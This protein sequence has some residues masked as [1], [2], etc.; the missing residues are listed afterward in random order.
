[1]TDPHSEEFTTHPRFDVAPLLLTAAMAL[2]FDGLAL[3]PLLGVTLPTRDG[4]GLEP[5]VALQPQL[6]V[7]ARTG[8]FLFG[9]SA[10]LQVPVV[11]LWGP[12][13]RETRLPR[14][15]LPDATRCRI[16]AARELWRVAVVLQGE[17]WAW[18]G[19]S[20]GLSAEGGFRDDDLAELINASG[21]P[22]G[23]LTTL[24]WTVAELHGSLFANWAFAENFGVTTTIGHSWARHASIQIGNTIADSWAA[25]LSFWFRTDA[26]LQR[27]WLDR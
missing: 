19:L 6:K 9:A 24:G 2:P 21:R 10:L 20:V 7:R 25:T 11:T 5:I 17:F 4:F 14:R 26:R 1:M 15:C 27:F 18:K 8:S 23:P 13:D 12:D 3:V 22:E 16:P